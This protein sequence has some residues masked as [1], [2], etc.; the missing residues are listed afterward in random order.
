MNRQRPDS[1]G[2]DSREVGSGS[3]VKAEA[4]VGPG[5]EPSLAA[6]MARADMQDAFQT[7][8]PPFDYDTRPSAPPAHALDLDVIESPATAEA[9]GRVDARRATYGS[10]DRIGATAAGGPTQSVGAAMTTPRP[11][12][13]AH[14]P[15]GEDDPS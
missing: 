11:P 13:G 9:G 2:S 6:R 12:G 7:G 4:P 8:A 15:D 14:P 1:S 3:V 10:A 5:P